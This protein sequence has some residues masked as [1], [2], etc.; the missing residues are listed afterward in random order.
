MLSLS[1]AMNI[2]PLC[3]CLILSVAPS[4]PRDFESLRIEMPDKKRPYLLSSLPKT[5]TLKEIK[6]AF[7]VLHNIPISEKRAAEVS[8]CVMRK[9]I[10]TCF[11]C[12][13]V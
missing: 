11:L 6:A 5:F 9:N 10:C 7:I 8:M 1:I 3:P 4:E 13:F 12:I 2:P